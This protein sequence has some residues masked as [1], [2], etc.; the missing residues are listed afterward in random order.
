MDTA[1]ESAPV[2]VVDLG[3]HAKPLRFVTGMTKLDERM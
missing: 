3:R 2:I 1:V